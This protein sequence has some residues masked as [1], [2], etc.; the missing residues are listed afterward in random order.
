MHIV[1]VR[2]VFL[3]CKCRP[4]RPVCAGTLAG[5]LWIP[6]CCCQGVNAD[7][8][9]LMVCREVFIRQAIWTHTGSLAPTPVQSDA[10]GMGGVGPIL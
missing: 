8:V 10:V 6:R 3:A 5:M 1:L 9:D 7:S 2:C 4:W